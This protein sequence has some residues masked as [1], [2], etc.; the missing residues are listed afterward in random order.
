MTA[1][2]EVRTKQ[3]P[4]LSRQIIMD[5][6]MTILTEEGI[7]H[8]SMRNIA[9]KLGCSVAGPY[10]HFTNQ[11]EILHALI[12]EGE[13]WLTADLRRAQA[14][15]T[16]IFEQLKAIGQT[17]WNFANKNRELHKLIFNVGGHRKIFAIMSP[18][19]RVFLETMRRG[20]KSGDI[21][22]TRRGY[23]ALART[24]WAW[25]YGLIVLELTGM[26]VHHHSEASNPM[27]EGMTFFLKLLREGE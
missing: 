1:A 21:K 25:I 7:E 4:G 17:Y 8:L 6:S 26:L 11:E 19:Y 3:R 23:H 13:S 27:H 16:D 5:A 9:A 10:S 22:Y 24:I 18:S 15:S 2:A 12:V 14:S 20:V